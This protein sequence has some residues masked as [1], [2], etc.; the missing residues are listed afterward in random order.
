MKIS[1]MSTEAIRSD[2]GNWG[3]EYIK[4]RTGVQQYE[5][6]MLY[7]E[8]QGIVEWLARRGIIGSEE[9]K[10]KAPAHFYPRHIEHPGEI[11]NDY[12]F[13]KD[14]SAWKFFE[15]KLDLWRELEGRR[16]YA[17]VKEREGQLGGDP[18]AW[19]K[20]IAGKVAMIKSRLKGIKSFK[21]YTAEDI[22][23]N[24]AD[25]RSFREIEIEVGERQPEY[26]N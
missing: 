6:E 3:E 22:R 11:T 7:G 16:H 12:Y 2:L 21:T 14:I 17:E 19:E 1:Q 10:Y 8:R 24:R 15:R 20:E 26:I 25:E 9:Y 23:K 5:C 18:N 13:I 4:N